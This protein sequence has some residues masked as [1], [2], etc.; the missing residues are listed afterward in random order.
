MSAARSISTE[1]RFG[2]QR[3]CKV[4]NLCRAT[5]YRHLAE[6]DGKTPPPK[7]RGPKPVFTD[8]EPLERIRD[9]LKA[10]PFSG[11][12]YRKAWARLRRKGIPASPKRVLRIMRENGL[13]ARQ[14][15]APRE[16]RAHEGAI[17]TDKVDEVWGT[18]MSQTVTVE[19][20]RACV[21]V[22][23]DHCS[24]EFI[25]THASSSANR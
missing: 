24:G 23:V 14:R 3:V 21:F 18:D 17:T 5:V 6:R 25:G 11:E 20:G 10:S 7:T 13:L 8:D 2:M 15:H 1:R 16:K 22:A 4:W 12:G 19:R 9:V